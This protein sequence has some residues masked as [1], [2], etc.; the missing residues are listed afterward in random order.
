MR[1]KLMKGV[2]GYRATVL[3]LALLGAFGIHGAEASPAAS[4]KG[5][6]PKAAFAQVAGTTITHE[7]FNVAFSTAARNKFFHGKAGGD[8]VALLQREVADQLVTRV[9][10]LRE[11]RNRGMAA[12]AAAIQKELDMYDQ[13]YANSEHWKKNREQLVPGLKARLEEQSLLSQMEKTVRADLKPDEA[14]VRAYFA[15]HA[16]KFT[17]PEQ[18][19]VSVILL[20]IDPSSPSAVWEK[21]QKEAADIARQL[22]EGADFAALARQHSGDAPSRAKG[23]DMGYVHTGMLPDEAQQALNKT[24]PGEMTAPVKVLQGFAI[25]RLIGRKEPKLA[26]FDAVRNRAAELLKREQ[27]EEAWQKFVTALKSQSPAQIDQ[28]HFLPLPDRPNARAA[29]AR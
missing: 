11:A 2:R 16:E 29:P 12:D 25:F 6:D 27:G 23:G 18:L 9:L 20:K 21:M 24:K 8:E 10:L 17:E 4:A 15:K 26:E 3:S 7:E 1:Q 28:T 13:R 14:A 22:G 5:A 19:H